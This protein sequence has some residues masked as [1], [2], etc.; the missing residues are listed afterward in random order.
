LFTAPLALALGA[1][2]YFSVRHEILTDFDERI[3]EN[4]TR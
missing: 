2:V 1:S 4:R 3:A